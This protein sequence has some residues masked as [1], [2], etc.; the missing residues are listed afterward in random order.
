MRRLVIA[1]VGLLTIAP[2][3][4]AK[5]VQKVTACGIDRCVSTRDAVVREAV[6]STR[7]S[8]PLARRVHPI[9]LRIAIGDG[10]Q[11]FDHQRLA[12][13]PRFRALVFDAG[14]WMREIKQNDAMTK[15]RV[16]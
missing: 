4:G 8:R 12:W 14:T 3:T 7:E 15:V 9:V 2:A 10:R 16:D 1:L 13:V 11:V 5:E 6:W